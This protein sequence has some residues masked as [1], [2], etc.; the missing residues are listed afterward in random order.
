M[1]TEDLMVFLKIAELQ[2]MHRVADEFAMTQSAVTKSL[3]RV[4]LELGIKL[5]H[6]TARGMVLTEAGEVFARRSKTIHLN[7]T[8]ALNEMAELREGQRGF[9]RF[10]LTTHGWSETGS[11]AIRTFKQNRPMAKFQLVVSTTPSLVRQL[12]DG[13]LDLAFGVISD[14]IPENIDCEVLQQH[15]TVLVVRRGHPLTHAEN[16]ADLSGYEWVLPP[17]HRILRQWVE[18]KFNDEDLPT[19][20]IA[21]ET[22]ATGILMTPIIQQSDLIGVMYEEAYRSLEG[23]TLASLNHLVPPLSHKVGLMWRKG[24]YLSPIVEDFKALL[25]AVS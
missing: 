2:N 4:E 18:D 11:V 20:N 22:D 12:L 17:R 7:L 21:I 9:I 6:R 10:G 5:F 19:P 25:K 16:V 15:A 13:E 3:N 1:K 8:D 14:H 23:K 24:G